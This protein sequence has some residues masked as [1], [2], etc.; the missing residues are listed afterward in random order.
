LI[1]SM[2]ELGIGVISIALLITLL[3]FLAIP[4]KQKRK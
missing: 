4:S 2:N 1:V 3:I